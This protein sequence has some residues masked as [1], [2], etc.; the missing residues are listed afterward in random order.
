MLEII[1]IYYITVVRGQESGWLS[2]GLCLGPHR[3]EVK[4]LA[5]L[6]SHLEARLGEDLLLCSLMLLAEFVSL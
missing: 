4:V 6:H 3:A 5:G 1:H 2:W